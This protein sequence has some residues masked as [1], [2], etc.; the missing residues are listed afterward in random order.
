MWDVVS[1]SPL[2]VSLAGGGTDIPPYSDLYGS[3]VV[4]ATID[5]GVTLKYNFDQ[6]PLEISSRD[7]F[8]SS[9]A[10]KHTRRKGLQEKLADLFTDFGIS[11]GRLLI[12]SDVPPGSGLGSSSS[13]I[14]AA[15]NLIHSVR[16]GVGKR[17]WG[18]AFRSGRCARLGFDDKS[19]G[20]NRSD[21]SYST[22]SLSLASMCGLCGYLFGC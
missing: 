14:L 5:R 8:R 15:L 20:K 18:V 19:F 17:A 13:L 11:K 6:K 12:N 9:I 3:A 2:R 4:N 16:G 21:S 22:N 7:F 10:G 1:Y